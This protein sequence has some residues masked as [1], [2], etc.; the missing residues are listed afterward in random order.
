MVRKKE[1]IDGQQRLTTLMLLLRAFFQKFGNMKDPN[2]IKIRETLA[3]CIWKTDEFDNP[4][5]DK[6][7]IDSEVATDNDKEEFLN[8][9]RTGI[10]NDSMK[11]RYAQNY[12]FFEEK[13][14]EFL[15][16]YSGYFLYLPTRIMKN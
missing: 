16:T 4:L 1:I 7:K 10:V 2:S 3:K 8:I 9:L 14:K 11:S 13:I 5:T 12:R 15:N 6:L